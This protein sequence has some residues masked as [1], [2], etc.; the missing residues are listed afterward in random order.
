MIH[1]DTWRGGEFRSATCG[2]LWG[3]EVKDRFTGTWGKVTCKRCLRLAPLAVKVRL[4]IV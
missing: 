4:G 3:F 1:K 2:G